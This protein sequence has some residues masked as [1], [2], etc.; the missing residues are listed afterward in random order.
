ME[1]NLQE[2][3]VLPRIEAI[4]RSEMFTALGQGYD[5]LPAQS[6]EARLINELIREYLMY[7]GYQHTL[8]VFASGP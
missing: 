4:L 5:K 3:G 6:K 1:Q 2:R 8:G 7:N